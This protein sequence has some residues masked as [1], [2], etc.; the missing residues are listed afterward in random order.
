[1]NAVE[2]P[3]FTNIPFPQPRLS[4]P[5]NQNYKFCSSRRLTTLYSHF[6]LDTMADNKEPQ[7]VEIDDATD[8]EMPELEGPEVVIA[9][10]N[11]RKAKKEAEQKKST[12][13]NRSEKKARKAMQK[14]GM[15]AVPGI[16]RVTVKKAKNVSATDLCVAFADTVFRVQLVSVLSFV[17]N[18][19]IES[20]F[21]SSSAALMYTSPLLLIHT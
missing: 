3:Y 9:E 14:L 13:Q 18:V 4:L 5:S 10:L 17:V 15:K 8:D 11:E 6:T 20:R 19:G 12:K 1:M 7:V 2:Y 16:V 21:C